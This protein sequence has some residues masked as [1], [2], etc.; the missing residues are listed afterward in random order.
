MWEHVYHFLSSYHAFGGKSVFKYIG[1]CTREKVSK[2]FCIT[3]MM[4]NAHT[5]KEIKKTLKLAWK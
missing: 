1:E 2:A 3:F 5:Q 4:S